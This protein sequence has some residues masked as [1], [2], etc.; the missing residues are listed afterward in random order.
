MIAP[1][2][3]DSA[4]PES[5]AEDALADEEHDEDRTS[6][7]GPGAGSPAIPISVLI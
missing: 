4:V 5:G 3:A 2:I 1:L 6:G 7:G